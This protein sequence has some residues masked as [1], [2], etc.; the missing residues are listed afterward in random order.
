LID[1]IEF[2][3][4]I[5]K[6]KI[7]NCYVFCGLDE[8]IIKDS[9]KL[10]INKVVNKD[11][12]DFNYMQFDG[13]TVDSETIINTCE[14]MPFMSEKK[15]VVVYRA[16]FLGEGKG[17]KADKQS[18]AS[19]ESAELEN[20][21]EE[22][23]TSE[24]NE[25]QLVEDIKLS[26]DTYKDIS[27]YIKNLPPHCVLIL[28]YVFN[29]KRE[30]IS[31]KIKKLDKK[32]CV[33][34]AGKP[35]RDSIEK[36]AKQLFEE[37]EKEIGTVEL[38][39]F[40]REI[41]NK[42]NTMVNEVEKLCSYTMGRKI[43]KEDIMVMLPTETDND[44]FDFVDAL[45]DKNVEKAIDILNEL[46]YKGQKVPIIL[47]MVERQ[48]NLLFK[49]RVGSEHGKSKEALASEFKLHP[50]V[51]GKMI[52]QTRKFTIESLKKALDLCLNAEEALKS[53]SINPIIEMELLIVSTVAR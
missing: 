23:E 28:Y 21:S 11:F 41:E 27:G 34:S 42:L 53:S 37:R 44:I 52:D 2:E 19:E 46:T 35:R 10:I 1:F 31:D 47:R 51:C 33:V 7:E 5:K 39:L 6:G 22:G 17:K 15:V 9:V 48:F 25:S 3:Q 45:G 38:K 16:N 20:I 49:L 40:C 32:I 4:S 18:K 13:G 43:T 36:K 26:K 12:L 29:N 8:D 24:N 14:T 30:K 50:Y